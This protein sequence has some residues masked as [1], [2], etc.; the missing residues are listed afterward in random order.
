MFIQQHYM[1]VFMQKILLIRLS[2]LY[3]LCVLGYKISFPGNSIHDNLKTTMILIPCIDIIIPIAYNHPIS[4]HGREKFADFLNFFFFISFLF[5]Y[6]IFFLVLLLKDFA[7]NS[8]EKEKNC[9]F[10]RFIIL[11]W[12]LSSF[13]CGIFWVSIFISL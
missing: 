11:L 2:T 9:F 7:E 1:S 6:L 13:L 4:S 8:F 5:L 3:M 10:G 12:N